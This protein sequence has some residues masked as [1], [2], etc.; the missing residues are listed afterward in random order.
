MDPRQSAQ[1]QTEG[2]GNVQSKVATT[3]RHYSKTTQSRVRPFLDAPTSGMSDWTNE[4]PYTSL[5]D[6]GGRRPTSLYVTH[7]AD[8]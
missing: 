3:M 8:R 6:N 4:R 5:I 2:G 1:Q 7:G